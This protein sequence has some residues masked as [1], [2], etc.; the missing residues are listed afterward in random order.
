MFA[1]PLLADPLLRILCAYELELLR[2]TALAQLIAA[3]DTWPA[4][5]VAAA[6]A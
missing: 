4:A 2:G 1:N 3:L 5:Y 6:K